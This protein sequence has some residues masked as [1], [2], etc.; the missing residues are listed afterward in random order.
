MQRDRGH[1]DSLI[2][3]IEEGP[4]PGEPYRTIRLVTSRGQV[5][6]RFYA[7]PKARR[8][9]IWV[10]GV[11]GDWDTPARNLYPTLC[12]DLTHH[13]VA[14]L[15]VRFRDPHELEEAVH[16]VRAGIAYLER[17]GIKA[18]ALTGHSFGG[19]VVIRAAALA[20]V[21]RTVVTLAT[22]AYGAEP[23]AQLDPHCSILLLHGTS[24]LVLAPYSSEVVHDIAQDPKGLIL[25]PVAG[26]GLDEVADDVHRR[27]RDWIIAHLQT[28]AA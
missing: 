22:Q 16:D 8:G 24:D 1:E 5:A 3:I 9:A 11:G 25:Y 20:P 13:G 26:H 21:V 17:Q 7:A 18:I 19:A 2:D 27:V 23:V 15:R 6:C 10:G 14:S 28:D 4:A 12:E